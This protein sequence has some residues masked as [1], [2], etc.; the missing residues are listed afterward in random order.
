MKNSTLYYS[1][2]PLLYCPANNSSIVR[3]LTEERFGTGYSLALCLEDTIGDN[4]VAQAEDILIHSLQTLF[5]ASQSTA[6]FMP[7]IFIRVRR[8]DQMPSLTRRLGDA[9]EILT[10]FILPKFE[11]ANADTYIDTT[12]N[13][14]HQ[15][16]H[17]IYIMP[18]LESPVII[19]LRHR[20]EILYDLKDRLAAIDEHVLNIRVGGNDLCNYFGIRR[21]SN[22]SIHS[23]CPVADI[24]SDIVTV[25]GRDYVI[26]GPVWEYYNGKTGDAGLRQELNEDRLCGFIG[27]TV[28][29]PKQIPLIN[30]AYAVTPEDLQDARSILDWSK[31]SASLVS[32]NVQKER[33]NEQKTHASWAQKI[34]Y[35][36]EIYGIHH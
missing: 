21:H 19:D 32:G 2:G 14:Q 33:M 11:P 8:A 12:V 7:K 35:L 3:S 29:H 28:I 1:I 34:I 23:I 17:T 22:E 10:G 15:F 6:F 13:I 25:F 9:R 5:Q 26:S 16:A 24:F 27:K 30:Q 20:A 31:D 18:I 4:F 36:S